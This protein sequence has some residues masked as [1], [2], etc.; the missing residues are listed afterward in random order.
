MCTAA[1]VLFTLFAQ[2]S[3]S[4]AK[5]EAQGLLTEGS[6]LYE[7][8][9]YAGALEKFTAAYAAYPSPKLMFNI[10]Q[11]DRDL[12]RPVEALE[13]F[14]KFLAGAI[15]ASPETIADARSSVT[16]L[17]EKLGRI[18]IVCERT[19]AEVSIDGKS[20]GLTPVLSPMW[21]TPGRHQVT[22]RHAS[23]ALALENVDVVA[24]AMQTVVLQLH[25]LAPAV[26]AAPVPKPEAVP[27]PEAIP[28][29]EVPKPEAVPE[30]E[31]TPSPPS[32]LDL[33]ASP[34]PDAARD[35]G[36]WL[37]RKWTWVAA[38]STVLLAAGAISAG[39]AMQRKFSTLDGEC[40]SS[41]SPRT[42]CDENQIAAVR[43]RQ[44]AANVLWSLTGAAAVTTAVLFYIEGRPVSVVPLAAG[45]IGLSATV[46]Y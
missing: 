18:Q 13:A 43:S 26:V 14:E 33:R 10:G 3:P 8:G 36:W 16:E 29:S 45:A 5:T 39:V 37:G 31:T 19:G 38:G 27:E 40:G 12:S 20:V 6:A 4:Q 42:G 35:L 17:R 30:P 25:A 24:G 32:S 23:A 44:I 22:A 7:R 46:R 41:A 21:A 11:A 9:D 28:K 1:L 2:L 15:D 34:A